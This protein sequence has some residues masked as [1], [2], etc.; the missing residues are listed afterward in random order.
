MP[1]FINGRAR[2]YPDINSC[3]DEN[4]LGDPVK[5][6]SSS[7]RSRIEDYVS[8]MRGELLLDG[9]LSIK[10]A[11]FIR[12][13]EGHIWCPN[14]SNLLR[15]KNKSWCAHKICSTKR[16]L[17]QRDG[18]RDIDAV[19]REEIDSLNFDWKSGDYVNSRKE[20][21]VCACRECGDL[22]K[23][24]LEKLRR[25]NRHCQ[26]CADRV[27]LYNVLAELDKR[28]IEMI[29]PVKSLQQRG[30]YTFRCLTS[31]CNHVWTTYLYSVAPPAHGGKVSKRLGTGCARCNGTN[32]NTSDEEFELKVEELLKKWGGTI[33]SLKWQRRGKKQ[34]QRVAVIRCGEKG[35]V[36]F[37]RTINQL[38]KGLWCAGCHNSGQ[39]EA[40]TRYILEQLTRCEFP[41]QRPDW[42]IFNSKRRLELDGYCTELAL[43]FEHQGLQHFEYVPF[44]HRGK[45]SFERQLAYDQ[46]KKD[47]CRDRKVTLIVT[48]D[49][50]SLDQLERNIRD[51]LRVERPDIAI[52]KQKINFDGLVIGRS[53]ERQKYLENVRRIA[54]EKQGKCLS[55]V[56]FSNSTHLSFKCHV[57]EHDPW[58][59][60]YSSIV[61]Q[62][63]WC[64][65]CRNFDIGEKNKLA[66]DEVE[67][68]CKRMGADLEG[69]LEPFWRKHTAHIYKIR[70]SKCGHRDVVTAQQLRDQR[71]CKICPNP[72]RGGAQRLD[73]SD[74]IKLAG[75]RGGVCLSECYIN[76][77]TK[78]LWECKQGH[79]WPASYNSVRGGKSKKGSWCPVCSGRSEQRVDITT[80]LKAEKDAYVAFFSSTN[81][82]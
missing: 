33:Q 40:Y 12:C 14:P 79:L 15:V 58:S 5:S 81:L 52:T 61:D 25:F 4:P 72:G 70:Y 38:E 62:G 63:T 48:D 9:R 75:S 46:F 26:L 51:L 71:K 20:S 74:A 1:V 39:N 19:V 55:N 7:R 44:F 77:S 69:V 3:L 36:P 8:Y 17:S 67:S 53:R 13:G 68:R 23:Y 31:G 50:W 2:S 11:C 57:L 49:R 18:I 35:H 6:L 16:I 37:N 64:P 60:S 66:L 73:I 42:L 22:K 76:S 45:K 24:S 41:K 32:P 43:A 29:L 21:L 34:R 28:K 59:S 27:Y 56:Y 54:T 10:G 78:L 30:E 47:K 82:T 65:I 80:F